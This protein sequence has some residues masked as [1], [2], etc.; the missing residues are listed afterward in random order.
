[1]LIWAAGLVLVAYGLFTG[2]SGAILARPANTQTESYFYI[3]AGKGSLAIAAQAERAG[4]VEE[5]WQFLFAVNQLGLARSLK[6]G[7]F[8]I[9]AGSALKNTLSI[10]QSGKTYT[11]RL[12]IPEGSS[13][14]EVEKLF[15][16]TPWIEGFFPEAIEGSLHPETYFYER[17]DSAGEIVNRMQA[18]QRELLLELWKNRDPAVELKS[19]EEAL[20]L[21]SIVEKE[22][23][24][25][26]ERKL[27]AAVFHNRL[28]KGMRLRS[29]PTVIYGLTG[30]LPL[31]RQLLRSDIR[32]YSDYNTH[33]I[34]GLPPTPIANPGEASIHAVLNPAKVPYLYFVADGTGG[35]AFA[36]TLKEHN[37][38]VAKW[39]K[40]RDSKS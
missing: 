25:K 1:M 2:L 4:L 15:S 23:G 32:Q 9:P 6:A 30:G 36:V 16:E 12:R 31:G 8:L 40:I 22:T 21:A 5:R 20:N 10:I 37:K 27:V 39:R 11:R 14:A 38:N 18:K 26:G 28:K 13:V 17:G 7:E 24:Q 29:D 35:H 3:P 33:R 34:N 19:P